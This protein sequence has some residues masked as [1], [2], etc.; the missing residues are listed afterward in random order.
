MTTRDMNKDSRPR[1]RIYVIADGDRV[2]AKIEALI[3]SGR[4][5]ALKAQ[6]EL[7]SL[8]IHK[9]ATQARESLKAEILV[10]AGDD[11]VLT[12]SAEHYQRSHLVVIQKRF[13][14][15]TGCTLSI[16]VGRTLEASFL[17]WREAKC[18]GDGSLVERG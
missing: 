12:F 3:L 2:G 9:A 1:G 7:L 14:E 13:F 10:A 4:E 5:A 17:A 8:E 11:L 18:T 6:S 16:G 15:S